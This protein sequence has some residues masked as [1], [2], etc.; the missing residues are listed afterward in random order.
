MNFCASGPIPPNVDKSRNRLGQAKR[1]KSVSRSALTYTLELVEVFG[2]QTNFAWK[3]V[4]PPDL[5]VEVLRTA[6]FCVTMVFFAVG[7]E[8][9]AYRTRAP[10]ARMSLSAIQCACWGFPIALILSD[11]PGSPRGRVEKAGRCTPQE[12]HP[13]RRKPLSVSRM[14]Q[15]ASSVG[16]SAVPWPV[17][18]PLCCFATLLF[19]AKR[20]CARLDARPRIPR[21]R[22]LTTTPPAEPAGH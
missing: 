22:A 14:I 15:Y 3:V 13:P 10:M 19:R 16:R 8:G 11:V 6:F 21:R 9:V 4:A 17:A 20:L 7:L 5:A 2:L 12:A 1:T 18:T